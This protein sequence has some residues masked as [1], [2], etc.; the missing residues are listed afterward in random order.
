MIIGSVNYP[1]TVGM[2]CTVLEG[3]GTFKGHDDIR[4]K[5][6]NF[7]GCICKCKD[8]EV[9]GIRIEHLLPISPDPDADY[10]Q[11]EKVKPIEISKPKEPVYV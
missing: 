1:E 4:H 10:S 6:F 11:D 7:Y 5:F 8:G 9:Y 2:E 3:P